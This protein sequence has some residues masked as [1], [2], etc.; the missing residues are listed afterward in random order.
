MSDPALL[1]DAAPPP[2]DRE[3]ASPLARLVTLARQRRARFLSRLDRRGSYQTWVL[4]A[5]LS[6]MFANTFPVTILTIALRSIAREF[7]VSETTIAWVLSAPILLSAV[8]L[9]LLGKLGDLRG[10][11]RVF[12]LGSMA[13]TVTAVLTAFAWSAGS[14]IGLRALAAVVGGATQPSSMA[15]IFAVTDPSRRARA[16]GWWSMTGAA[17]PALGLIAGGPLVELLGWRV[18]FVIQA[19]LSLLALVLA[20]MILR[21]TQPRRV[22]FDF[23]GAVSLA[24]GVAGWMLAVGRV[25]DHGVGSPVIWVPL[26]LGTTG[27]LLFFWIESRTTA[28]L[29]PLAF[30]RRRNFTAPI[31]SGAFMGAAYMGAFVVAPLLLLEI[32]RFSVSRA[33]GVMLLRTASLSF[34][35][36]VGGHLGERIGERRAAVIGATIMTVSLGLIAYAATAHS[37]PLLALGLVLQGS[38]HGLGL[39]SLTAAVASSVGEED[40]G[41]AAAVNRLGTQVGVAFGITALSM[42]YGG[43]GSAHAFATAFLVGGI[44]SVLSVVAALFISSGQRPT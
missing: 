15:L 38:G 40:L 36:P 37:L 44:F 35:S 31:T 10:H 14:L 23:G 9:P 13:A 39:P 41:I 32:F 7:E 16:M 26:V 11:R 43:S 22:R 34:A 3:P 24:V 17:A 18:V 6:G 28:P 25:R 5:T 2:L 12:L 33:A 19:G 30:L 20:S 4:V 27:L 21:E 29:L 1:P 8:S 42:A